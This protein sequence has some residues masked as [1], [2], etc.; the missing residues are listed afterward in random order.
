M[1]GL[2][3]IQLLFGSNQIFEIFI[4]MIQRSIQYPLD[5][6]I[7]GLMS[8]G[9]IWDVSRPDTLLRSFHAATHYTDN[10][11][12]MKIHL[13]QNG[14]ENCLHDH[15]PFNLKGNVIRVFSVRQPT[16]LHFGS[17]HIFV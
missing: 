11:N 8:V 17:L 9:G 16:P 5:G 15:I 4:E 14:K 10:L 3:L 12:Q 1:S 13:V 7:S 6:S 2:L